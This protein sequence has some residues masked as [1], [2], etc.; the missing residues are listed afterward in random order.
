MIGKHINM[1]KKCQFSCTRLHHTHTHKLI[2][3]YVYIWYMY[4]ISA[5]LL[6]VEWIIID[7]LLCEDW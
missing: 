6:P 1:R 4:V 7:I 5:T 2:N 3:I